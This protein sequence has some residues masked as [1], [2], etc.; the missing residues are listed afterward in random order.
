MANM[1]PGGNSNGPWPDDGNDNNYIREQATVF[2]H[3]LACQIESI[4][5]I[6]I[7]IIVVYGSNVL[8][9]PTMLMNYTLCVCVLC[10][11]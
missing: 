11:L 3:I 2:R 4:I 1:K 8:Q 5:I 10:V 6:I 7:I 9:A